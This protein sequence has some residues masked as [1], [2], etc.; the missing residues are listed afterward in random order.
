MAGLG[1]HGDSPRP[2][3]NLAFEVVKGDVTT[4]AADLVAFKYAQGFYGA[5]LRAAEALA[6]VGINVEASPPDV[7]RYRLVEPGP[8][9]AARQVLFVGVA[10]LY[11]LG[12]QQIRDFGAAV[13]RIL[14]DDAPDCR[15][16]A[17]TLHGPGIGLDEVEALF[18]MLTGCLEAVADRPP[19]NLKRISVVE[20]DAARVGRLRRALQEASHH[21]GELSVMEAEGGWLVE[22]EGAAGLTGASAQE[23]SQLPGAAAER[24]AHIFVAMPFA[25]DFGDL[26]EYGIQRPVRDLGF[27]CERVDQEVFTG[28]VLE[29]IKSQIET[30]A[31][32]IAVLTGANPN[33]YLEVGY[34]WGKGRPTILVTKDDPRFDLQG[35]RY[36]RYQHIKDVEQMLTRDLRILK[37]QG[38][39]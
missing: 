12:Y 1:V 39:I 10:P 4:F 5:D 35:Q 25:E 22:L 2:G 17:M 37:E 36:L 6:E 20:R 21:S 3:R 33:V 34:A 32:I 8:A 9:L 11:E 30:S 16:L 14:S 31:A 15:H 38:H 29:R 19:P 7:G 28:D 24:K 26:F 13:I 27:L 23:L 18:S